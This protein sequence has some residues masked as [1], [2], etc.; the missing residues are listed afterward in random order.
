MNVF[1]AEDNIV[2]MLTFSDV[3]GGIIW[4]WDAHTHHHQHT[5]HR[6][7]YFSRNNIIIFVR[8]RKAITHTRGYLM[9]EGF[10]I[11][12]NFSA[13]NYFM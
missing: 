11:V 7:N 6:H 4:I 10:T 3:T 2:H 1:M 13:I 9:H 12:A 5:T 8:E